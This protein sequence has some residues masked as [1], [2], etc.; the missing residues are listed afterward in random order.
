MQTEES[1][2]EE[3]K[4]IIND[5]AREGV[6]QKLKDG[7]IE[8]VLSKKERE[9]AAMIQIGGGHRKGGKKPKVRAVEEEQEDV[10][11]NIDISILNLFGFLK[12]SP[13]LDKD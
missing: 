9:A 7:K 1:I 6:Q 5:M 4:A 11:K 12:T 10:F 13:P 2:K 3:T 8:A